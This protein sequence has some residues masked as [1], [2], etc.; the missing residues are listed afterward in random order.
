[1]GCLR[2]AACTGFSS[3]CD[4]S[5]RPAFVRGNLFRRG[6]CAEN[7]LVF[8]ARPRRSKREVFGFEYESANIGTLRVRGVIVPCWFAVL[9]AAAL[10]GYR[11]ARRIRRRQPPG[12]CPACGYDLRAT[13]GRCPECGTI[14]AR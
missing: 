2:C 8:R 4:K 13:P 7:V 12:H 1:V 11:V 14:P 5:R 6:R 3:C 10:P 9:I